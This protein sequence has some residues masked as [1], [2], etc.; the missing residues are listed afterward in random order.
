MYKNIMNR[1]GITLLKL[2]LI[3]T[4]FSLAIV[5]GVRLVIPAIKDQVLNIKEYNLNLSLKKAARE[6]SQT[7]A[8]SEKIYA[9]PRIFVRNVDR[10]DPDLNY[11]MVSPDGKSIVSMEYE[12]NRFIKRVITKEKDNIE[13]EM[14]FEKETGTGGN[15]IINYVINAYIVSTDADGLNKRKVVLESTIQ[16]IGAIEII[17]KGTGISQRD[18][19]GATPSVALAYSKSR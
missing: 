12:G 17:D 15:S 6:I 13:Y 19:K 14:F 3:V 7:V 11:F 1:K 2:I 4:L 10:M 8:Y 18:V 16:P 9:M 5:I